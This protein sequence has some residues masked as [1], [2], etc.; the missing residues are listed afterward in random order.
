MALEQP[1]A[2]RFART[3]PTSPVRFVQM[4]AVIAE[5]ADKKRRALPLE[6]EM[7]PRTSPTTADADIS[8]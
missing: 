3:H 5:I 6:P 8:Y 2:I 4:Q 1:A 7:K